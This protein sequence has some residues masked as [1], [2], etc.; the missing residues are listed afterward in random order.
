MEGVA[1]HEWKGVATSVTERTHICHPR[2]S[3]DKVVINSEHRHA[4]FDDGI[5][6]TTTAELNG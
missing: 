5:I 2:Q 4:L 3:K 1:T 6:S